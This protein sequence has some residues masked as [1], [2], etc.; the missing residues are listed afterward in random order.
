[1]QLHPKP[2][3]VVEDDITIR[4]TL[5]ELL[6]TEGYDVE[7]AEHGKVALDKLNRMQDPPGVILLDIT[8]PVMDGITF[9]NEFQKGFP[10]NHVPIVV[11]SAAGPHA[12]P[13]THDPSLV[14]RK[15]L[16]VERLLEV[17]KGAQ[18]E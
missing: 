1:M 14:L 9:L 8:M 7:V 16:D 2:I 11:M 12:L 3:L 18:Q 4:E 10:K 13:K 17:I 5:K 6:T 15:P